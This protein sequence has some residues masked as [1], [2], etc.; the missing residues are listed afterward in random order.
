MLFIFSESAFADQ[1]VD[2][3]HEVLNKYVGTYEVQN[4]T[5][6]L[7]D[8]LENQNV[9]ITTDTYGIDDGGV[10]FFHDTLRL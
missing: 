1:P 8:H 3:V 7:T 6:A 9:E 10:N 4:C 5:G 2:Q